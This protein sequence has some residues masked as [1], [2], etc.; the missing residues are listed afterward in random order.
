MIFD[1]TG[2]PHKKPERTAKEPYSDTPNARWRIGWNVLERTVHK[3]SFIIKLVNRIIGSNAGMT[4]KAHSRIPDMILLLKKIGC[5]N[6]AMM[7][8]IEMKE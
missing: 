5:V 3:S 8:M 6:S 2:N 1:A 4:Q 7:K